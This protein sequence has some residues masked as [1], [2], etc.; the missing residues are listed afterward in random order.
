MERTYFNNKTT[1]IKIILPLIFIYIL[2][3]ITGFYFDAR[4]ATEI[5]VCLT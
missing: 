4:N 1:I 5:F 3:I 2:S